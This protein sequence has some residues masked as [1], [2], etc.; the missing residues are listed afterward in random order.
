L[1]IAIEVVRKYRKIATLV[2]KVICFAALV[3]IPES[4]KLLRMGHGKCP[5]EYA[6]KQGEGGGVD[7][8]AKGKGDESGGG[9][10][11]GS[12]ELAEG[13]AEVRK[14]VGEEIL[15]QLDHS[16][17]VLLNDSGWAGGVPMFPAVSLMCPVLY[18][19]LGAV[20]P[21]KPSVWAVSVNLNRDGAPR[22]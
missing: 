11:W 19:V 10:A 5:D 17:V 8:D 15:S 22:F 4:V 2:S 3:R 1:E 7:A 9:E 14:E 18:N 20:F 13:V 21:W 6:V 12:A 16:R